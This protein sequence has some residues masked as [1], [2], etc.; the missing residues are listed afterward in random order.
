MN[1]KDR[2]AG[3]SIFSF[4]GDDGRIMNTSTGFNA[5]SYDDS[6]ESEFFVINCIWQNIPQDNDFFFSI[7]E[8][9][10][11]KGFNID[12]RNIKFCK[13]TATV[14]EDCPDWLRLALSKL[15]KVW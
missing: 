1:Y 12:I 2:K 8:R 15:L 4:A 13:N 7:N 9:D 6:R 10:D 14:V 3:N 5:E 11:K